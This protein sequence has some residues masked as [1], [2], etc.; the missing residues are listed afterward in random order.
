MDIL[1]IARVYKC[2]VVVGI[3]LGAP[4]I[5]GFINDEHTYGVASIEEGAGSGIMRGSDEVEA[6]LLHLLHL[7][8]FCSIKSHSAQHTVIVVY[9]GS[10]DKHLLA[11]EHETIFGIK[12]ERA[13]AELHMLLINDASLGL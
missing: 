1:L 7:A 5:K 9:A 13:D 2:R 12:R 6:C 4:A 10:V 8:N 3:L 11:V